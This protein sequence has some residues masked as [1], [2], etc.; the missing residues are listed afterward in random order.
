M[1]KWKF[2]FI[3]GIGVIVG[4]AAVF[5]IERSPDLVSE[6]ARATPNP[7]MMAMPVPVTKI[8]KKTIP[9]YLEY[10]ARTDAIRMSRCRRR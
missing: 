5:I 2:S 10:S 3:A 8:V 4:A 9:I 6:S 1:Q 7:A